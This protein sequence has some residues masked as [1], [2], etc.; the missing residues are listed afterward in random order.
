MNLKGAGA[1]VEALQKT[2][3]WTNSGSSASDPLAPLVPSAPSEPSLPG[4]P[5]AP[6]APGAPGCPF[7][8]SAPLQIGCCSWPSIENTN[9]PLGH[10][11][12]SASRCDK[13]WASS[14]PQAAANSAH[15]N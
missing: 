5:V 4:A 6:V 9:P 7:W 13:L 1:V 15:T 14:P 8:P 10:S 3:S 2:V 11:L 12:D